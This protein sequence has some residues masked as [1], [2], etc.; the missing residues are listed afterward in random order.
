MVA[1]SRRACSDCVTPVQGLCNGHCFPHA[2]PRTLIM[3]SSCFSTRHG[4]RTGQ[5]GQ[6]YTLEMKSCAGARVRWN[7]A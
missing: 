4:G 1:L 2:F 5:G 7:Y 6:G 3:L